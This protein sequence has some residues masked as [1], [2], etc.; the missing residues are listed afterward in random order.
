MVRTAGGAI[1]QALFDSQQDATR[2]PYIKIYINSTDYS[3][4]LMYIEHHEE[5]YREK[6]I[7]GLSNRDGSLDTANLLGKIFNIGYGYD[8]SGHGGSST[9]K[10]DTAP[11]WVKSFSI[12]TVGGERIYQIFAEGAWMR[13]RE[14]KVITGVTG[15]QVGDATHDPYSSTFN[16]SHTIYALLALIIETAMS[17][18]LVDTPPDDE[19]IDTFQPVFEV[20]QLPYESAAVLIYRLMWM[21]KCYL[22]LEAGGTPT[23]PTF[24]V[25]FPQDADPAVITY[26]S[27]KDNWGDDDIC[28]IEYVEKPTL[29][30]PNSIVVLTNRDPNGK[31]NTAAYPLTGHIGTANHAAS[32]A[33]YAEIIQ[34]YIDGS[35]TLLADANHRA[36]AILA[37]LEGETLA[38]RLIIPHDA[39]LELYDK[40][41]IVDT[42]TGTTRTWPS[43]EIVRVTNIIHRYNRTDGTYTIEAALG[44][45]SS[46][47]GVP[48]FLGRAKPV[49]PE[50][51]DVKKEL[52]SSQMPDFYNPNDPMVIRPSAPEPDF[53]NP[54]DP[55]VIRTVKPTTPDFYDPNDPLA[56]RSVTPT[57]KLYPPQPTHINL[58]RGFIPWNVEAGETFASEVKERLDVVKGFLNKLFGGK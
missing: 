11:L 20:N 10:V 36:E 15:P 9:D 41:D 25:I 16:A 3:S 18:D 29:L 46:D 33:A 43:D 30:I 4:R 8:S 40:I 13:L 2:T 12:I 37:R 53:Y 19:I 7:I 47:F 58:L 22:R 1:T 49:V 17:W 27:D 39:R 38:G 57:P 31:W 55:L 50:S 54:N 32:V 44:E 52:P 45:V 6:A 21:T 35:I 28:F 23:T 26:Q 51:I 14:Q 34:V 48:E 42:R 56:I 5:A 24:R